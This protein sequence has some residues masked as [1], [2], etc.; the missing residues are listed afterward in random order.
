[1]PLQCSKRESKADVCLIVQDLKLA[2]VSEAEMRSLARVA[3]HRIIR[4]RGELHWYRR[5]ILSTWS[6]PLGKMLPPAHASIMRH[7]SHDGIKAMGLVCSI[8]S[9]AVLPAPGLIND[10]SLEDS[11][12]GSCFAQGMAM[13]N[14]VRP[15]SGIKH[16]S[17]TTTVSLGCGVAAAGFSFCL[18]KVLQPLPDLLQ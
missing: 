8:S 10:L 7:V 16:C 15:S 2:T 3:V 4:R 14:V 13:M 18:G 6:K 1:M 12:V 5:V 9:G 17:G 11:H